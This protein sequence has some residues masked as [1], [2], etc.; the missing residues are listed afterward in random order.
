[1]FATERSE[2]RRAVTDRIAL[3]LGG[4]IALAIAANFL[5]GWELHLFLGRRLLGLIEWLAFWR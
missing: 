2:G 1:V 5:F 4:L 3:W